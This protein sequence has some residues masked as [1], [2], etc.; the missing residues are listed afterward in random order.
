MWI[1]VKHSFPVL[2]LY[3]PLYMWSERSWW[4]EMALVHDIHIIFCV[5]LVN[6]VNGALDSDS[7]YATVG[8]LL[9]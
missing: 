1:D 7:S 4:P 3:V 5:G 6:K 2:R 9:G 8:A